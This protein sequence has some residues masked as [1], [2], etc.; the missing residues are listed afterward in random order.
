LHWLP[1][2]P[3]E[4]SKRFLSRLKTSG[5][6]GKTLCGK[7]LAMSYSVFNELVLTASAATMMTESN[8]KRKVRCHKGAVEIFRRK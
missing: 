1:V 4:S 2:S 6:D 8:M 3:L 5:L 7:D